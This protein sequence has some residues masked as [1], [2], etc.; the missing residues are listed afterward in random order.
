M[1]CN[2]LGEVIQPP[3]FIRRASVLHLH[4]G[5]RCG[6]CVFTDCPD[7][8]G[9]HPRYCHGFYTHWSRLRHKDPSRIGKRGFCVAIGQSRLT[10]G[11]FFL[12]LAKILILS[13]S[14][15]TL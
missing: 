10:I 2:C 6:C 4:K 14:N 3:H 11:P 15:I 1:L 13:K 5:A 12:I 7:K 8:A 9:R